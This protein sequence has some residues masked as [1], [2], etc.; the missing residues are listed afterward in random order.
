M[1]LLN[2]LFNRSPKQLAQ[3]AAWNARHVIVTY[4]YQ[5]IDGTV[6]SLERKIHADGQYPR[7]AN[8]CEDNARDDIRYTF[9][10]GLEYLVTGVSVCIPPNRMIAAELRLP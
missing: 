9:I 7:F 6:K 10:T 4:W 2:R 5:D 3:Q 1:K 8:T